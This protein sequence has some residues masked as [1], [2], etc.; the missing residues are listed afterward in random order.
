[1]MIA[2]AVQYVLQLHQM[3]ITSA[4]LNGD[5][6][7]DVYMTQPEGFVIEGQENL[8]C[9]LKHS[10]YSL[11]QSPQCWNA[12]LDAQLRE[13]GFRETKSDPCI[14][15]ASEG[16]MFVIAVY[17]DDIIVAGTSNKK[18]KAVKEC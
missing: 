5:L 17:V 13:M 8:V 4:F 14:Y 6:Q 3:D 2:L 9:T 15:R 12:T 10:L 18:I 16:E 11:K 7:E 1:M